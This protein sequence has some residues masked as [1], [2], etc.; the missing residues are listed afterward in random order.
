MMK[1]DFLIV[2]CGLYG[3]VTAAR[4][5][6]AGYSCLI[7]EKRDHI[8]GNAYT[9]KI[10]DIHVHRYGAHIFHTDE[11]D[12]WEFVGRYGEF[13]P[14]IN[15]PIANYHGEIYN[16][17]FNMNTFNKLWGVVTPNEAKEAIERQ[18][19]DC[20]KESPQNLEEQAL[21]LVGRD[22]YEKLIRGYTQKQW[23][24]ECKDLPAFIIKRLPVRFTYNNNYFNDLHQGIPYEGYTSLVEKM[25]EGVE[26]KLCTDY[27][28]DKKRWDDICEKVIYTGPIDAYFNFKHGAL[29]YRS[30]RF[31]TQTLDMPDYQ[32]NAVV[33]YTDNQTPYTR[34][35]EHRHFL[36][37]QQKKT[38]IS[39]EYSCDWTP[40][41]EPYYPVNNE[42]NNALYE[43]YHNLARENN[44][45]VFGGRLAEYKYYDMDKV[46]K[47][48][49]E[50]STPE[51]LKK[52][53]GT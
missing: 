48:A 36:P 44:K 31:E 52:I 15:S 41:E 19:K 28:E 35:I 6:S 40:G 26:I 30:L 24:C 20:A 50:R 4:I 46:I 42:K 29:Q 51:A 3:A 39:R 7:L 22:I 10:D 2:G 8:A 12:V 11:E 23:G 38:V 45:V 14:Y 21:S 16:L 33:N 13:Y 34:V 17:P 18:K 5:K 1:Y 53:K 9:E 32:G 37:G 49:L 27:L 43:K 47:N 25:T